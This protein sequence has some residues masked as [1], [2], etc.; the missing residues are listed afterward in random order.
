VAVR[1]VRFGGTG[2]GAGAPAEAPGAAPASFDAPALL[3]AA[4]SCQG[5]PAPVLALLRDADGTPPVPGAGSTA[6]LWELLASVAAADLT[7]ARAVEPH[8]DA[9]AILAQA[10]VPWPSG[11]AWGV[12]AAES[13]DA[14]L[15]GTDDGGAWRLDGDK[16]WC[17]LAAELDHAVVTAHVPGGRRAFAV[18]LRQPG[19]A[20]HPSPWASRGLSRVPSGPLSFAGVPARPVGGTDWYLRRDGFAWGGIGVAACW[21][22]GAVGLFRTLERS[23]RRREPDQLAQ[24]WLGEAD[25]LLDSAAAVLLR[26]ADAVDAGTAGW[27]EAHRARGHVASVCAR[28]L[29]ICGEAMGPGPLAFDEEH[30]RRAADLT[31][32]IRQH[33]AAR[34]DAGLGRLVAANPAGGTEGSW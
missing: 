3:R 29:A 27:V 22:G 26:A 17:S 18:D 28:M 25:R 20:A 11:T 15:E 13:P 7:A 30:A 1:G 8:L 5:D 34:D 32:Y 9:A 24:A 10:G 14:R 6:R 2:R 21:F 31:V 16:P 12:F 19:V 4:A 33:H 23:A